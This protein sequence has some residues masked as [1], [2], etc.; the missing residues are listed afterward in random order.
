M[1]T[2]KL[3]DKNARAILGPVA[4]LYPTVASASF[5]GG[6][7]NGI[8]EALFSI[9]LFLGAFIVFLVL[10]ANYKRSNRKYYVVLHFIFP[11]FYYQLYFLSGTTRHLLK[12][13]GGL[14]YKSELNEPWYAIIAPLLLFIVLSSTSYFLREKPIVT[15]PE[16]RHEENFFSPGMIGIAAGLVMWF[17]GYIAYGVY[18]ASPFKMQKAAAAGSK[19]DQWM[20]ARRYESGDGVPHDDAKA[21]FWYRKAADQGNPWSQAA[22]AEM[23]YE[24]RG[25]PKDAKEAARLHLA[26]ALQERSGISDGSRSYN[27]LQRVLAL[28]PAL[29][30]ETIGELEDAEA[31]AA[32]K[33]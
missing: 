19:V 3:W 9:L 14:F 11:I 18:L 13:L 16:A 1:N 24:G 28:P 6:Y 7:L 4:F 23:Y 15:A 33:F 8:E 20:L 10:V 27:P 17:C 5:G 25:V 32:Y 31:F 30:L 12:A 22:L 2:N 26:A 21:A 29:L